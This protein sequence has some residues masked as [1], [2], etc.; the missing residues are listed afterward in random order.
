MAIIKRE[1]IQKV[2]SVDEDMEKME[3]FYTAG[4]NVKWR[5]HDGKQCEVSLRHKKIE[6]PSNNS[7]SGYITR[8]IE[9]KASNRYLCTHRDSSIMHN[10]QKVET[11]LMSINIWMNKIWYYWILSFK[12]NEILAHSATWINPENMMPSEISQSPKASTVGFHLHLLPRVDKFI[13]IENKILV[14]SI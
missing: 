1:K 13:E 12:R 11:A 6:L 10:S 2:T 7:T 5:R 9:S 3:S 14:A 8:G 4:R